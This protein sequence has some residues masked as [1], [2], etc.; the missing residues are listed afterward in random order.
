MS[1]T[2]SLL[3]LKAF[4]ALEERHVQWVVNKLAAPTSVSP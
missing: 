3:V 4:S 1:Y 2:N